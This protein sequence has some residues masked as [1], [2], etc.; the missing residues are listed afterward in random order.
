MKFSQ[1]NLPVEVDKG[2]VLYNSK[3]GKFVNIFKE[4]EI[5][6]FIGLLSMDKL[7]EDNKTV[8]LLYQN[9]YVVDDDLNEYEQEK[10]HVEECYEKSANIFSALIFVTDKCNF[11]CVYCPQKHSP[12]VLSEKNWDLLY[13]YLEKNIKNGK[14]KYTEIA[15]F[16]GEP[17][18]EL[19]NIRKFIQKLKKLQETHPFDDYYYMTTNAYL[20]TPRVYDEL[21]SYGFCSFQI[22]LDGFAD[23]HDKMRPRADGSGTWNIIID[24]LKYINTKQDSTKIILRT[25]CNDQNISSMSEFYE[26]LNT[27][28]DNKKFA[29]D[30]MP[31]SKFSDNVKDET[32]SNDTE[33]DL[34]KIIKSYNR[35]S[36]P[37]KG[38][39]LS[40]GRTCI[41]SRKNHYVMAA[42][43]D[44]AKCEQAY[45]D[46]YETVAKIDENGDMIFNSKIKD[47][48][49]DFELE[50][51]ADCLI[52]PLCAARQCM[53][54]K[55]QQPDER[56]DCKRRHGDIIAEVTDMIRCGYLHEEHESKEPVGKFKF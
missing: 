39:L 4:P 42:N 7:P 49:Q 48:T 43:G 23:T 21:E 31:V 27:T 26:Y 47:W 37:P 28:F 30:L 36:T 50:E 35:Y 24:N 33:A 16:G 56:P 45:D 55:V 52:Y 9:G 41:C 44:I 11:R 15:F 17:L 29:F 32:L 2:I 46:T 18:L 1:Y 8:Q 5:S 25:N 20:L 53:R 10:K 54:G 14:Y 51:C 19:T 34:W 13:K 40:L 6:E 12:N 38:Q 22:T 3:L